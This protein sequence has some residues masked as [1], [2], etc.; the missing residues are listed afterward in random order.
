MK[1]SHLHHK[2]NLG[3]EVLQYHGLT[4]S[5]KTLSVPVW[6]KPVEASILQPLRCTGKPVKGLMHR[7]IAKNVSDA[8]FNRMSPT[9]QFMDNSAFS[10]KDNGNLRDS[11]M[12]R[13]RARAKTCIVTGL[14]SHCKCLGYS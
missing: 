11:R 9:F 13:H 12:R 6:V 5:L 4:T 3:G 7:N 10:H 14:K 2:E 8:F 1:N